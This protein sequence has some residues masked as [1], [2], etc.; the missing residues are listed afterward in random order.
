MDEM[1]LLGAPADL[2][3][4]LRAEPDAL[5]KSV[6]PEEGDPEGPTSCFGTFTSPELLGETFT[7]PELLGETDRYDP[8]P[9]LHS[10]KLLLH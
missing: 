3:G 1:T 7:S 2:W 6:E 4:H 5:G 10:G 8:A 9:P